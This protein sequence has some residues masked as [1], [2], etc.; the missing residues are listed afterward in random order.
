MLDIPD[1]GYEGR[2]DFAWAGQQP[3]RLYMLATVPRSGSTWFSHLLWQSG[4]LGAPLE[5][6][7]FDRA[8]PYYFAAH[9]PSMQQELWNSVLRRRTSPNGVFGFKCFPTQIQ[10]L[11]DNNPELLS[12][13]RPSHI[14][15]LGR[16]DRAAHV[17]SLARAA[18]SGIWNQ[19]QV[20]GG[21]AKLEY[22]ESAIEAAE[23]GIAA[24]EAACERLFGVFGIEPLR[25]WYEDALA[26]PE[27]AVRQVADHLGVEVDRGAKV[28]VPEVKKQGGAESR[29]WAERYSESRRVSDR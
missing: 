2:F 13:I 23:N 4:C 29:A 15:H 5:Y 26:D 11:K 14:L 27:G 17:V 10:S 25:L 6:L 12:R 20:R 7:N 9:S 18:L 22:S 24:Q 1:T 16:R 19:K 21:E 28:S 3:E 8:G